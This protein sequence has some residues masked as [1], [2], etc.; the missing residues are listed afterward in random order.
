MI[1]KSG[2]STS[3]LANF[4]IANTWEPGRQRRGSVTMNLLCFASSSSDTFPWPWS[5]TGHWVSIWPT[6]PPLMP[7][8]YV[9]VA[10]WFKNTI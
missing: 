5:E 10:A 2:E 1:N 8:Y 6:I 7:L 3:S 9:S 4:Q